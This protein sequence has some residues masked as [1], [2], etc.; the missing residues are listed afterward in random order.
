M[1]LTNKYNIPQTFMNVL[2]R[3]TYSKGKAHLS[4]TQLLNSPK[5][6]ALTK[7]FELDKASKDAEIQIAKAK[8]EAEALN[9]KGDALR[10]TPM[11]IA[12]EAMKLWDGKMPSTVMLNG[13]AMPVFDMNKTIEK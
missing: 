4:V 7:K 13:S 5:I 12:L 9:I 6:V 8:G 2:D 3:P 11:L 1:K 10:K